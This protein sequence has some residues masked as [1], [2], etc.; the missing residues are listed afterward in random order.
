LQDI[1][2]ALERKPME[3]LQIVFLV[4]IIWPIL[5]NLVPR[6]RPVLYFRPRIKKDGLEV[7]RDV[8]VA[9]VTAGVVKPVHGI[10]LVVIEEIFLDKP[11]YSRLASCIILVAEYAPDRNPEPGLQVVHRRM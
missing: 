9:S 11:F 7:L 6:F 2:D 3:V 1:R 10:T 8:A 4:R 5:H